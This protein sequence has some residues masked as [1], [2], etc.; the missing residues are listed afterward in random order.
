[1]LS[2]IGFWTCLALVAYIYL[3]Y[4]LVVFLLGPIVN[5]G[6]RKG[7]IEPKV[8]VLIAAFD[9]E[10]D[11]ERT[12]VNKLTQDYPADRLEVI[13]ARRFRGDFC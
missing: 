10:R 6:V 7:D 9:E 5:R 11:I 2:A 12:V 4:P 3:G 8:T 1:M 13:A